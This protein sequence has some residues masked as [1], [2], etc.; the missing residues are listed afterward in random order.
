MVEWSL[1][2][3]KAFRLVATSTKRISRNC[4]QKRELPKLA[5]IVSEL[6]A[7]GDGLLVMQAALERRN[8]LPCLLGYTPP[9][10]ILNWHRGTGIYLT[11]EACLNFSFIKQLLSVINFY[12]HKSFRYIYSLLYILRLINT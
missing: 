4:N 6:V 10:F 11:P 1:Y 9:A 7:P 3:K 5:V 8:Q 2:V 12:R